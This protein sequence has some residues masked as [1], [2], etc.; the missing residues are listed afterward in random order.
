VKIW[1]L[2]QNVIGIKETGEFGFESRHGWR[3]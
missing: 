1:L 2:L 3:R